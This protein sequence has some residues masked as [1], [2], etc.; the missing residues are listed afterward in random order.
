MTR[1]RAVL[2]DPQGLDRERP[3]DAV[4]DEARAIGTDHGRLAPG[5]HDRHGPGHDRRVGERRRDDLDEGHDR[6]RVEEVEADDPIRPGRRLGDL[7]DRERAR[8][9]GQDPRGVGHLVERPEDRPLQREIL[10]R[11]FD[12]EVGLVGQAVHGRDVADPV[13][14]GL[15]PVVGLGRM[16]AAFHRPPCQPV[17]DPF[18][19]GVEGR[20]VDVVEDDLA[21]GLECHLADP[22]PHR[23]GTDDADDRGQRPARRSRHRLHQTGLIDSNG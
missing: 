17:E 18:A 10:E 12:D 4:D 1:C 20:L 6:G 23:P 14:A 9:G 15:H 7:G 3:V 8:V 16:Q 13:E 22:G 21:A 5:R 11:R 19:R 2:E